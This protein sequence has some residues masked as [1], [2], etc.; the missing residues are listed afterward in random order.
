MLTIGALAALGLGNLLEIQFTSALANGEFTEDQANA[1][2][3]FLKQ[4][5]EGGL[6]QAYLM[7]TTG[8]WRY[9]GTTTIWSV[10][11]VLA[12]LQTGSFLAFSSVLFFVAYGLRWRGV[13]ASVVVGAGTLLGTAPWWATVIARHGVV[14]WTST[15]PF[16]YP[17]T[18]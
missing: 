11:T 4:M 14:R 17:V 1:P 5:E 2:E 6:H 13:V 9:V 15:I 12:H 8:R 16:I 7:Y 18:I 3:N 10:L